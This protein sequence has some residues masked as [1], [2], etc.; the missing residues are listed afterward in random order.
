MSLHIKLPGSA[1]FRI[2]HHRIEAGAARA[3]WYWHRVHIELIGDDTAVGVFT[4]SVG[5]VEHEGGV[6]TVVELHGNSP[7][8][9]GCR[10]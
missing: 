10:P 3:F 1:V 2:L 8:S 7:Y 4:D 6:H 5:D 9:D